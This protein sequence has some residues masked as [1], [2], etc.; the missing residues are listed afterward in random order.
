MIDFARLLARFGLINQLV[1][2]FCFQLE[3]HFVL[4]LSFARLRARVTELDTRGLAANSDTVRLAGAAP[5]PPE[6]RGQF[7]PCAVAH[8]HSSA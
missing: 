4:S 1:R 2:T 5:M 8:D 6:V 3:R 7:R